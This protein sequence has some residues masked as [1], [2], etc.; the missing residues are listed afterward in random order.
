M[1]LSRLYLRLA[2][3]ILSCLVVVSEATMPLAAQNLSTGSLNVTVH[4]SSG[5]AING[6]RL[7]LRD[8]E[9]N[10]LHTAVTAGEGTAVIPYL[11]PARY[12][13]SVTR[14][15]FATQVFNSVTVQTNQVTDLAVTLQVGAATQTV[16]VAG[17]TTPILDTTQ[18][19]LSTTVDMKEVQDLPVFAR[20]AFALAF[21][22]PGAVGNNFDNLPGGAVDVSANGFSTMPN[23][24]KSGGFDNG[25]GSVIT[26]R[27]EDVQEMTVQTSELDAS[28]GGTSTMD[29]GFVTKRGTNAFHGSLFEDYRNDAM[30]ANSWYNNFVGLPRAKLII[31]DFGGNVGGPLLKDKLFFF[32]SLANLREPQKFTVTTPVGTAQALAGVYSYIPNGSTAVQTDNVLQAG[33]SAGCSTCT[34]TV[35]P[36]IGQDISNIES[37]YTLPGVVLTP[38]D[39]N[40]QNVN[41]ENKAYYV[42]KFPTIRLDYNLTKNFRLTGS[43]NESN[44][45]NLNQGGP[46]FPGPLYANQAYSNVERNYQAVTGFDWNLKQNLVNALRVGYLYDAFTY[47]SQGQDSPTAAMV[48]QGQLD[49][50]MGLNSGVNGFASLKG[51][52]L[53]PV[54]AIKDNS[55]WEHGSHTIQFGVETATEID[56]YYNNQFV[57]YIGVNSIASG[58]PVTSALV[59]SL[60]ANAPASATG[61]VEGL[62]ATLNGRMTYYSLGQFVNAKTKQFQPGISFDLHERLNQTALFFADSWRMKP[63]LTLNYGLRW[64]F[65]GASKDETGFYTHPT[66][67]NMWGPTPVGAIFQPGNLG[68]IQNPIEGPASEAYAPTYV[69]PEPNVGIAWNP[70]GDGDSWFDRMSGKGKTVFRASYTLKNYTEGAQNF[71]NFGS[72]FGANFNTYFIANPVAPSGTPPGAGFYNAGSQIL[73]NPLPAL[74][75]TSPVPYNPIITEASQGF[76]GTGFYTFDPNIK[77]PYVQSWSA[78]IERQLSPNNV[79]EVRYVGNVSKDQWLGVN[80]NEI[81]IF[82]NGFLTNFKAAQANLAASGGTTFQGSNPTPLFDQAFA[83]TGASGNYTNGQFITWLQQGQAG[84]LAN[85]LANN[86][87]YLCSMINAAS[88][89]PCA[90]AGATGSGSYPI[91]VFQ[92][93]PYAAGAAIDE[94]TND[95]YSNY[96]ALQVDFRQ[97]MNHGMQFD[98]NYTFSHSLDNNVQGSTSPGAYSGA[99]NNG[100]GNSAPTYYTLR[101]KHLNYFPSSFDVRHV[102]H[103]SGVYDFPFGHSQPLFSQNRVAD[104]IIGGWTLGTIIDW[105]SGDPHLFYGGSFNYAAAA[106]NPWQTF[107]QNDGGVT[108]TGITA[109]Q[110]QSQ[111]RVRTA[112]PGLPWKT[113]FDPK[114]ISASGQANPAYISSNMNP[115]TIGTLLWLHDPKWI[116]TDMALTKVIPI[117]EHMNFSLQGEFFNVFNHVAWNG[118]D[119]FA[120]DTT[121]GTTTSDLNYGLNTSSANGPRNIEVRGNFQF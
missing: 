30:N 8:L 12:S 15:G 33:A 80:Y 47:N 118:M 40:H 70:R 6:A 85:A 111:V 102:L 68:G 66:I 94:M 82:E 114:Y 24:N 50:G 42:D 59:N 64:D 49:W 106:L 60:P 93:N 17:D 9:T 72:N 101:D 77:Q 67:P 62:Y 13:L 37:T 35:N 29:I 36:I 27:L 18:N 3:A 21:L 91:N 11:N 100:G 84:A 57:P 79:L 53:Y 7:N 52:Q 31:D 116:N 54:L 14:D 78:G 89:T 109:S 74:E 10:D 90:N 112:A 120:Q 98:V 88:F 4:D 45:Y 2:C 41:F 61:D 115:G 23:R 65:T 73:G 107:N 92:A 105:Q 26:N 20:D 96:N 83:A 113:L 1:M 71:W 16:T 22:V 119:S 38:L 87:S 51:G 58:D 28:H 75:S 46:P 97:R 76:T 86:P 43:A 81:N 99:G 48:Q 108:L 44:F 25:N 19:A 32:A 117:H 69:H 63:D 103:A 110:L 56:H 95:G 121:F 39:L 34:A 104:A 5:A 55:T